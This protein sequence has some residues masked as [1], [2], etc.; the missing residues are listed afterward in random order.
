ML[1][2]NILNCHAFFSNYKDDKSVQKASVPITVAARSKARK[3][4]RPLKHWDRGLEFH[5]K[6]GCLSVF[7]LCLCC[8]V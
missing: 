3:Y 6:H 7:I 1:E 5:T 4:F 8:P 2:Y